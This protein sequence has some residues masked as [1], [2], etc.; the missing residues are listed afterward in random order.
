MYI[1]IRF[2]LKNAEAVVKWENIIGNNWKATKYSR[3]CSKHFL[4]TDFTNHTNR[5]L[6]FNAI[7]SVFNTSQTAATRPCE[8]DLNTLVNTLLDAHSMD[9]S[10]LQH[11]ITAGTS[12]SVQCPVSN[13]YHTDGLAAHVATRPCEQD[14]NTLVNTLLDAHSMDSSSLQHSITAGTSESVQC[15]VSNAYHTDGLAA[16]V[17]TRPCEQDPNTLVNT[18]LDAH[19]MDSSS[20]QHSITAGTS[21]SVQCPVS[22]AYHT[23]GLAAH[24]ATRP[25]EQDLNTLVNTLLDAHSMDSSSLQHSITA[26]TSKSV[27]CPV[28]NAYHT[29]GLA[30]HVATRPC[31]QDP[32]T[33]VNT[34]LDAHSMDSSSLQHSITAGTSESVQCPVSNAYHTDGL[35]AHVAT[36][37][38]EQDPNTLVNTL[39]GAHSM[40]SSSLQHSIIAP[41][42]VDAGTS[43]SV[44]CPVSNAYHTDGLAAHVATRPCEQDLNTLVNTL[45]GAHSMDSSSLQ[46]SII[47]PFQVDAGTSESVQCPVSNAYHTDGLAAHVATRP[48]EQ[49][50]NTLVNTLIGAHSMDSSRLQHSI[51]AGTSESVQCPVSNAYHTDGLAAHVAT[52][53]CEQDPNT[54]VNTLIGA[55]SMD[56]SS[57]QHS[58]IAPFQVDAGTSESVQ[59]PVSNAYHTDGLAAHVATRPCEQDLNTLVNTLI[60]AHSMDSSSLQHSIIAPFQVDAGTSESVQCPVSNAYHTDGL[61]AHVATRPCEQDLNT[62]VNT[63]IGAHSM[64]L[65]TR[66]HWSSI[67]HAP[68]RGSLHKSGL[69]DNSILDSG[70]SMA[71]RL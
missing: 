55:H 7:P 59:C 3:I 61:A 24:V 35:A 46:H 33:L 18:L 60:G 68:L 62:L 21:E 65:S 12:E 11:S 13:A 28:S 50:L 48:C 47:A 30:A 15:P 67:T 53:P 9:S 32:N 41:F 34:L 5:W 66:V 4:K 25:C 39:I 8:Q 1:F 2:P 16:H 58:I 37:P 31:E 54:L 52:R 45:I 19:S 38:C 69:S 22:N 10:S 36:R 44:Q 26:G 23:D 43:E 20:L 56:S 63:L 6:K 17:A 51:T 57:L 14:L 27:Q 71:S 40:D 29:D 42:Q 49:D 64:D 70:L